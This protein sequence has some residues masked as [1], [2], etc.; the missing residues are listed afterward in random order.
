MN[1]KLLLLIKNIKMYSSREKPITMINGVAVDNKINKQS[2]YLEEDP[3]TDPFKETRE[4]WKR[5]RE[6]RSKPC[7][8][9]FPKKLRPY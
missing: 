3:Y 7:P 5:I 1:F 9:D 8:P 6:F 2:I 4:E